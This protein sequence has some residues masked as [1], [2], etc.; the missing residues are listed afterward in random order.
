MTTTTT[1]TTTTIYG[2]VIFALIRVTIGFIFIFSGFIKLYPIEPFEF[3]FVDIG[4]VTWTIAPFLARILICF[5]IFLGLMFVFNLKRKI[6]LKASLALLLFFT[7]YLIYALVTEGNDRNCGCFGTFLEMTPTQAI[8]KNV[9]MMGL[10]LLLFKSDS[11]WNWKPLLLVSIV[12]LF[13]V[14]IPFILNPVDIL[15]SENTNSTTVNYPLDTDL[16]G[17]Y[18][19]GNEKPD[20]KKGKYLLSFLSVTCGH[21]KT[22]GLKLSIINKKIKLPPSYIV[23]FGKEK[24][25]KDFF[26]YTKLTFPYYYYPDE[27][28]FKIIGYSFPIVLYVEDGIIKKKWNGGNLN[29]AEIEKAINE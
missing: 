18:K 8:V 1:T 9:I 22:A 21:C 6:T 5:E 10:I 19:F 23:L 29:Q 12:G 15:N 28:I 20:L 16:L 4:L 17:D 26:D 3:T 24:Y 7:F 25:K 13:S 27:K 2:K 11:E 14:S